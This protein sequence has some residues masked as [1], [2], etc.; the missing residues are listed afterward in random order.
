MPT[1]QAVRLYVDPPDGAHQQLYAFYRAAGYD[2][3]EFLERG[4]GIRPDLHAKYYADTAAQIATAQRYGFRV[5]I[6]LLAAMKQWRGPADNGYL[7]SF[8]ALDR[9]QL[10]ERLANLEHAVE[11]LRGADG[12]V[13]FAGDPGGD[14]EGRSTVHDCIDF[15]RQVRDI[16]HLQAPRA[17]FVVNL[18][19]VAEWTGFPSPFGLRFWQQQVTASRAVAED[20]ALLGPRCGVT[21]SLD[22]AYRS[23]ALACYAGAG[24]RPEIYPQ[25]ADVQRL[26]ARGVRPILGWPYFLVDEVDDGFITPN[27]VASRGQ[28]QAETRYIRAIV[29][30]GRAVGLDGLVA[31]A[32]FVEAEALNVYAFGRMCREPGL[33]PEALLDQYARLL[34]EPGSANE[35]ALVLRFIENHS[36]WH[37]S[38]PPAYRLPALDDNGMTANAALQRLAGVRPRAAAPIALPEPPAQYLSRLR[39][40]VEAIAAGDIGG[41]APILHEGTG[42]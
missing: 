42:H 21:F 37:H 9:P 18:W 24:L 33:K 22:N 36:N 15:A 29:D 1:L 7:A 40:R 3:F 26:H 27:N 30:H 8:S 28:S 10:D 16:V 39:R 5:W 17:G 6:L 19:A 32:A 35:L 41:T 14:P 2:S 20:P 34:A 13:F 11:A 31:N 38:L 25:A 23:L 4:F 12:F